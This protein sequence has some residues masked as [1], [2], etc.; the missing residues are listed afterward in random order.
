MNVL[1]L[2][3][4]ATLLSSLT[5]SAWADGE[6]DKPDNAKLIVGKWELSKVENDPRGFSKDFPLGSLI[7]FSKD[8]KMKVTV[9]KD[10]KEE[11]ETMLY[12]VEGDKIRVTQKKG[13]KEEELAPLT[14]KKIAEQ[15]LVWEDKKQVVFEFKRLK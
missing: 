9:K 10:G 4:I 12:K 14:I 1:R 5:V 8:G 6:K 15:E 13:D 2:L 11:S 7:E 3:S